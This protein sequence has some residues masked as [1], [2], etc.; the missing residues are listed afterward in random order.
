MKRFLTMLTLAVFAISVPVL[1]AE[2]SSFEGYLEAK[3]G[4]RI[5]VVSEDGENRI[6]F[7]IT[8][9][10]YIADADTGFPLDLANHLGERLVVYYD[11]RLTRSIPP[12]GNAIA[13]I[14]NIPEGT[15]PPQFGRAEAVEVS[16][17]EVVVTLR[18]GSLL[19]TIERDSRTDPFFTRNIVT[20][21]NIHVGSDLLMW[22]PMVTASYPA[23]AHAQRTVILNQVAYDGDIE[24]NDYVNDYENGYGQTDDYITYYNDYEQVNDYITDY[25]EPPY[26]AEPPSVMSLAEAL[27][28]AYS[29]FYEEN[30]VQMAPLRLVAEAMGFI[31]T[32][33]EENRSIALRHADGQVFITVVLDQIYFDGRE[34]EAAP[35]IRN[36]R[37]FVPV[38]LFEVLLGI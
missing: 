6:L 5:E 34:L 21:D 22:F 29:Q 15:I 1:A 20:I 35:T 11:G 12:I 33:N 7:N 31:V 23:L 30:G 25:N 3:E 28:M 14:G 16:E 17:D 8:R 10:T 38:S 37:T 19:V 26:I 27:N 18:N 9:E 32:W 24:S 36:D 13:V 2:I 4:D